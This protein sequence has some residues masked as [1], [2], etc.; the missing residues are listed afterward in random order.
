[1]DDDSKNKLKDVLSAIDPV[2]FKWD[3][4]NMSSQTGFIAEEI[5]SAPIDISG[6]YD[7]I[8]LGPLNP[9]DLGNITIT[10]IGASGSSGAYLSSNGIGQSTYT[11][12]SSQPSINIGS[13]G[14]KSFIQTNKHKIDIDELGDMMA[15]LKKRLLILTPNFEMHEKYPMLKEM[16]DEYKAMEKLL[17][18]PDS[19]EQ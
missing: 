19:D 13:D 4:T 14:T 17:G 3:E 18:G 1:M 6:T 5:E 12:G 2:E 9:I 7:T 15:T 16:Y 10:G 11:I 8:S